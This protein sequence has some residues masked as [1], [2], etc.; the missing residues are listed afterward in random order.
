MSFQRTLSSLELPGVVSVAN[1]THIIEPSSNGR[2]NEGNSY[3]GSSS[4]QQTARQKQKF[5]DPARDLSIQVLEKF[6]LVTRFAR[7]TTSQLFRENHND[8]YTHDGYE[9]RH[10]NDNRLDHPNKSSADSERVEQAPVPADPLEVFFPS[11]N[12]LLAIVICTD[13]T[14]IKCL[15]LLIRSSII[16][17]VEGE[18]W[19]SII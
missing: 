18:G 13:S 5:Q 6:S 12:T 7:E 15:L 16:V 9:M 19:F 8:G 3:E 14:K 10:Q 17:S 11:V 1:G 2:I 4:L